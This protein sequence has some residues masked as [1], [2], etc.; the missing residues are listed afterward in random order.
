MQIGHFQ[1]F[2]VFP[3]AIGNVFLKLLVAKD[4]TASK[5]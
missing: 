5:F 4:H 1:G 3:V 2:L